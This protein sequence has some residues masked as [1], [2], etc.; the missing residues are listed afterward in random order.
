MAKHGSATCLDVVHQGHQTRVCVL[1]LEPLVRSQGVDFAFRPSEELEFKPAASEQIC[2]LFLR[3]L[4]NECGDLQVG[5]AFVG[6]H[7]EVLV[8]RL[9]HGFGP[10]F[11]RIELVKKQHCCV[12][13]RHITSDHRST[14]T[15][16]YLFYVSS[17]GTPWAILWRTHSRTWRQRGLGREPSLNSGYIEV[18]GA[19]TDPINEQLA[20]Y[21]QQTCASPRVAANPAYSD[22]KFQASFSIPAFSFT[23]TNSGDNNMVSGAA[24]IMNFMAP[25]GW[26]WA[27]PRA[28]LALPEGHHGLP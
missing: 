25:L 17:V 19:T 12:D 20:A 6:R 22:M 28:L 26:S 11:G 23:N 8:A 2:R 4:G 16:A 14:L 1:V 27:T 10:A 18:D 3:P 9:V 24:K 13:E 15:E 21:L 5:M 7:C